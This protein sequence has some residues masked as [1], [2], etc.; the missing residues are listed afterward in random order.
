MVSLEYLAGFF[1]GEGCIGLS[2]NGRW[3]H[4]N[5]YLQIAN[6]NEA[7]LFEIQE[8][9]G[10]CMSKPRVVGTKCKLARQLKFYGHEAAA[11]LEKLQPLLHIKKEQARLALEF[12]NYKHLGGRTEIVYKEDGR[13][14]RVLKP[15]VR[16]QEFAFLQQ[17]HVLNKKGVGV[18]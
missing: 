1:D 17:M 10:G 2:V 3:K 6:T 14:L 8:C 4:V 7:I 12:W 18:V 13:T 16:A 5:L 15:E 11:L 9:F